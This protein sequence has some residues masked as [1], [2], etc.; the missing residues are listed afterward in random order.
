MSSYPGIAPS[1]KLQDSLS[2]IL[3]RDDA[4]RT[5]NAGT[6]FPTDNLAI[7]MLCWKLAASSGDTAGLFILS[8]TN[9]TTAWTE[10]LTV[11]RGDTRYMPFSGGTFTGGV[12]FNSGIATGQDVA[13]FA[14]IFGRFA[15][16]YTSA[17]HLYK[18]TAGGTNHPAAVEWQFNGTTKM[19]LTNAGVLTVNGA[20]VVTV[21]TNS[22]NNADTLGGYNPSYYLDWNNLSNKPSFADAAFTTVSAIRAGVSFNGLVHTSGDT[23]TG[24]LTMSSANLVVTGGGGLWNINGSLGWLATSDTSGNFDI[25]SVTS[26]FTGIAHLFRV[27]GDDGQMWTPSYGDLKTFFAL[28]SNRILSVSSSGNCGN[29]PTATGGHWTKVSGI[30][31]WQPTITNCT[32]C[33]CNCSSDCNC[34]C[35]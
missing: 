32:N 3:A 2:L 12:T 33:D 17:V 10:I 20:Q 27:A 8:Q 31:A 7:G 16:S 21:N 23:M 5:L 29:I 35:G 22:K 19:K 11:A 30:L 25:T 18:D 9:P 34:N 1:T 6:A 28:N 13:A 14:G 4:N 26:S 15:S 24:N